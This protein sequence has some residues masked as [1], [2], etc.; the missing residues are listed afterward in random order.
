M[1]VDYLAQVLKE[2]KSDSFIIVFVVIEYF[3]FI[4]VNSRG[5]QKFN[6]V[7]EVDEIG[8]VQ[9]ES[10]GIAYFVEDANI[11]IHLRLFIPAVV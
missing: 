1:L 6:L 4:A 8:I 9:Q 7:L 11:R 3:V 10:I 2:G 5:N